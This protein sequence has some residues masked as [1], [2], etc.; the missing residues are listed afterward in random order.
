[1]VVL[2]II[3]II[4]FHKTENSRKSDDK[5]EKEGTDRVMLQKIQKRDQMIAQ[6]NAD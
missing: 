2:L 1:M 4:Y 5:P 3:Y 6:I